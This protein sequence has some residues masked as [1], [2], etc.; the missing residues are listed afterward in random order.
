MLERHYYRYYYNEIR[1]VILF[2]RFIEISIR[3]KKIWVRGGTSMIERIFQHPFFFNTAIYVAVLMVL[4]RVVLGILQ[5]VLWKS[6]LDDNTGF[7]KIDYYYFQF[8]EFVIAVFAVIVS[9][10]LY[11]LIQ[12]YF[13][14]LFFYQEYA[15]IIQILTIVIAIIIMDLCSKRFTIQPDCLSSVE[16]Q[17]DITSIRLLASIFAIFHP[18]F[19]RFYLGNQQYN[20]L[21]ICYVAVIIGRFVYFDSSW[22]GF[23]L[24]IK[25]MIRYFWIIPVLIIFVYIPLFLLVYKEVSLSNTSILFVICLIYFAMLFSVNSYKNISKDYSSFW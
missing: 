21:T 4:I 5:G 3:H 11:E 23:W 20:N 10:Y 7:S 15:S 13:G 18:L 24:E 17:K 25:K 16:I 1:K 19:I 14:E 9:I 6:K 2:I 8:T 12:D 22:Q